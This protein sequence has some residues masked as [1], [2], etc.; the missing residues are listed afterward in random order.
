M[1]VFEVD[2]L[3]AGTRGVAVAIAEVAGRGGTS[4]VGGG[5]TAAAVSVAGLS[6]SMTHVSTGGGAALDLLSGTVLPGIE[7]LTDR[8]A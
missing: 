6:N 7:A 2:E 4:I 3:A 1:G 8:R 5:D